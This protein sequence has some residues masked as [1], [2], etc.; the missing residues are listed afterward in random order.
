LKFGNAGFATK[1]DQGSVVFVTHGLSHFSQV[2]SGDNAKIK[3][4]KILQK[5]FFSSNRNNHK[6]GLEK[7]R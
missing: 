1:F 6:R 4:I 3:G 7:L 5:I 2:A